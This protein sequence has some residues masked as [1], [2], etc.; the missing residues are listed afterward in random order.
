M[1]H[2]HHHSSSQATLNLS[3]ALAVIFNL[4]FV[5]VEVGYGFIAHSVS[6][7]SDA[8]HNFADVLG[9]LMSWGANILVKKRASQRYSYGYKKL[10]ILAALANALLL[11]LTSALIMS[12]LISLI[13]QLGSMK[14]LLWR[15]LLSGY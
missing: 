3:F 10:T 9:L 8:V 5:F 2:T 13:I 4:S 11:V 6:L 15:S 7:L 12:L 14:F 1:L